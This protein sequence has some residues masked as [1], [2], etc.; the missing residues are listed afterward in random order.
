MA[1]VSF[2]KPERA[3]YAQTFQWLDVT[4]SDTFEP[5]KIERAVFAMSLQASGTF[6]GAT[7]ALHGSLD[8]TTYAALDDAQGTAIGL[9]AA[10]IS[11]CGVAAM[12]IKPVATGGSSQ[13][14][15]VTLMVV[16]QP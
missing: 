2:T 1:E 5:V 15:D 7:V 10:G 11:A 4:E 3:P 6:G 9:S 8:G 13:S 12:W 16:Y 14:V